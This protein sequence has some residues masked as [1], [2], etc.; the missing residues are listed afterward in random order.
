[1]WR[2]S[3]LFQ[4][5]LCSRPHVGIVHTYSIIHHDKYTLFLSVAAMG[6]VLVKV[7]ITINFLQTLQFRSQRK[8]CLLLSIKIEV[9]FL[10][11]NF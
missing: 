3:S 2:F 9:D 8:S 11:L 7:G 4:R 1:M 6:F 10:Y 5:L